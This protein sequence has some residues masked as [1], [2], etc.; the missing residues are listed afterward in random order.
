[1]KCSFFILSF[2]FLLW[3]CGDRRESAQA[4]TAETET[5]PSSNTP[6]RQVLPALAPLPE[7]LRSRLFNECTAIDYIFYDEPF[8]MS[9][10]E[11]PAIQYS[12][13]NVGTVAATLFQDCRSGGHITYQIRGDI[14]LEGEFYYAANCG[15]Y[16]FSDREKNK[17]AN[18]MTQEGLN[19]IHQQIAQAAK[20][21][22]QMQGGQ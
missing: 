18:L 19:Y 9:L 16:V 4:A 1:M 7:A 21:R 11:Q 10:S 6:Q 14:V 22:Q 12:V 2:L 3:S 13:G 15:Y 5:A 20:M 8:T 17:Y